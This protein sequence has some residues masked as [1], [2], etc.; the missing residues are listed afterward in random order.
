VYGIYLGFSSD[1]NT[2]SGNSVTADWLYGIYL[3]SS[4]GNTLSGNVMANNTYNFGVFGTALRDFVN[5]VDASNYVDG[6]PVY[7]LMNRSNIVIS[8]QTCSKGVGYLGLVNCINVTVRGLTFA[9]NAQGLILAN[10]TDSKITD[11]NVEAMGDEGI[12]LLSSSY[13]VLSGND[14]ANNWNGLVLSSSSGD[15]LSGNN[16]TT[17]SYGITLGAS[18]GNILSGNNVAGNSIYGIELDFSS[19]NNTLSGNSVTANSNDGIELEYSAENNTLS[20]NNITANSRNGILLEG[21]SGNIF[22]HD[23]L[24]GNTFQVSSDGSPNTWDNGYPSG[25]N[26]WSDYQTRY[27]NATEIDSSGIWNTPYVIDANNT[28]HYPLMSPWSSTPPVQTYSATFIESGLPQGAQWSATLNGQFV[29]DRLSSTS[30]SLTFDV[31]NGAYSFSITSIGCIAS[32][33]SGNITV[34]GTGIT[35]Q[36]MFSIAYPT[37]DWNQSTD[38]YNCPNPIAP[39]SPSDEEGV[40]YGLASTAV[41]YFMHYTLGYYG[42]PSYPSQS[43]EANSTSD[44]NL[45]VWRWWDV[46]H[47]E[48]PSIVSLNNASLAVIFQ[49]NYGQNITSAK[50]F[51]SQ[52]QQ[53]SYLLANLTVHRPVVLCLYHSNQKGSHAVV[54]FRIYDPNVGGASY[55]YGTVGICLYD[56][57]YPQKIEN[58]TYS[59]GTNTFNYTIPGE[60]SYDRFNVIN[61]TDMLP[62]S[63]PSPFTYPPGPSLGNYGSSFWVPGY[64]MVVSSKNITLIVDGLKDY[65]TNWNSQAFVKGIPDSSGISEG[66]TEVFAYK[67]NTQGYIQ[68]PGSSK[69]TLLITHVVNESGQF[70]GY[71]YLLNVSTTQGSLNLTVTPRNSS[72]LITTGSN[73]LNANVIFFYATSQNH[74]IYQAS[75][76]QLGSMQTANFTVNNWQMLNN[77]SSNPVTLT[78]VP[79]FPQTLILSLF[80]IVT[81]AEIMV[82][83]RKRKVGHH[84]VCKRVR[85]ASARAQP[86]LTLIIVINEKNV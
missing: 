33:A 17:N 25:G 41:L 43:P 3:S 50:H 8:P 49:N 53:Y 19:D 60:Y 14:I 37:T 13:N 85:T 47:L 46:L 69:S 27:P 35:K 40:C 7:Y 30:N 58:A 57:N 62:D 20:N 56:P 36:I 38:S 77:T 65:F 29:Y 15:V 10:T 86:R 63:S 54:A 73:S 81:L 70:V 11:I 79:E 42:Y 21:S 18:S 76:I 61:P 75:N 22:Y 4:S 59:I 83:K 23:N 55:P 74:S 48:P 2:L 1:N 16:I 26:F 24:I 31:P 51:E 6:K 45:D 82:F 67:D 71:G 64:Y 39:F 32:P 80:M 78:T 72:L 66:G 28:D 44:L 52:N 5:Y 9:K 84:Q 12:F 34:N 68:D